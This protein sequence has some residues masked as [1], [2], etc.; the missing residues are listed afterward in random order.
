M[1]AEAQFNPGPN[2]A[3]G[4]PPQGAATLADPSREARPR[5]D[6]AVTAFRCWLAAVLVFVA[7]VV[8]ALIQVN[9]ADQYFALLFYPVYSA[10]VYAPLL[11]FGLVFGLLALGRNKRLRLAI[12]SLLLNLG[13]LPVAGIV[14]LAVVR[15]MSGG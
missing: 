7:A 9:A 4:F 6:E 11:L 15:A 8:V 5:N 2:E 10:V 1:M 14:V 12:V 13:T 3:A